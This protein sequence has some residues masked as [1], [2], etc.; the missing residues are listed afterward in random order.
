MVLDLRHNQ[1]RRDVD[2]DSQRLASAQQR[3][4]SK[5]E[6]LQAAGGRERW[7]AI[8]RQRHGNWEAKLTSNVSTS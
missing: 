1:Q 4:S 7:V 8:G 3:R 6:A 2:A 5:A